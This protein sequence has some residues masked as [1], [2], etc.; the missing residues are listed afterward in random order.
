M[1]TAAPKKS[2]AS[3]T[4]S[5][6]LMPMRILSCRC[7][8]AALYV[9]IAFWMSSAHSTAWRVDPML[10]IMPSPRPLMRRPACSVTFSPTIVSYA[11]MIS[12]DSVK[13]RVDSSWV[14]PST[15]VN[16]ID[17]VPSVWPEPRLPMMVSAVSGSL[18]LTLW[19][20]PSATS[21]SSE[22]PAL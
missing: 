4:T 9:V 18:A 19:P 13:P 6:V 7:G 12:C 3:S 1:L 10:A 5:P 22:G 21:L 20:S 2:P 16:M 15:S 17:T 11:F 8:L 14:E